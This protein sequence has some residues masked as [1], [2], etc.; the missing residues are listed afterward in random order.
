MF[1]K[2][3]HDV[4]NAAFDKL[5]STRSGTDDARIRL[6]KTIREVVKVADS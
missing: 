6:G 2:V 5:P 3:F 1:H 4:H